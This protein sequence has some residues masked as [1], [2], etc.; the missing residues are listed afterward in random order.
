[1]VR[2]IDAI[3]LGATGAAGQN[4]VE[5]LQNHP[6]FKLVALGASSRSAGKTY[7]DAIKDAIFFERTPSED[8]LNMKV[9]DI[10]KVSPEDYQ[11]AFS[12]LPSEIAKT[13]EGKFAKK[14]PVF[15]TASAYRN[16]E[17]VPILIPDVNPKHAKI[18]KKQ[19]EKRGWE[20]FVCPG[21]NCTVVGLVTSI[22][23][24]MEKYGVKKVHMV[25]SQSLSGAGEKGIRLNSEYRKSVEMNVLPYIDGEEE[26]VIQETKK[27]L[28]NIKKYII[29]PA[30]IKI[31]ATCTRVY[32]ERVHFESVFV[33]TK[34]ENNIK[35]VKETLSNYVSEPQ[36]LQLPSA[37]Q[38]PIIVFD[39]NNQP[40]PKLHHDYGGQVTLV[41]RLRKD[42]VFKNGLSYVVTSDNLDKGAGGGVV[43]SAE[44]L[45]KKNYF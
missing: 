38:K 8:I 45:K 11:I 14:I 15:S 26:K 29:T 31:G 17:D 32:V 30:E 21:P 36:K 3:V 16:E 23:P 24:I 2:K 40:Q 6:W 9:Q 28:G 22:K 5:S 10:D 35:D 33:E 4:V 43:L 37:P 44:Y 34:K 41:G 1:M 7:K 19:Q 25:S 13:I 20:G 18:V 42:P 27:I 12:A 39:D